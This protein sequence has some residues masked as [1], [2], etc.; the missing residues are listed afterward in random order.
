MLFRSQSWMTVS[1][2]QR[3]RE[4]GQTPPRPRIQQAETPQEPEQPPWQVV[5]PHEQSRMTKTPPPVSG[6]PEFRGSDKTKERKRQPSRTD[7]AECAAMLQPRAPMTKGSRRSLLHGA[8]AAYS[9]LACEA[10]YFATP[11]G[12]AFMPALPLFQPAG[13]TSP[14]SSV[15]CRASTI[16]IISSILRPSGRSFTT[17]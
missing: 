14:C 17:W 15:N 5:A 7:I 10:R 12:E 2:H 11:S 9:S 16:R 13:Q 8:L 4:Q 6:R 1:H 3:E